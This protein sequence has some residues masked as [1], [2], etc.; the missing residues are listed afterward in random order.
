MEKQL[1]A[2]EQLA[3]IGSVL[4]VFGYVV[5]RSHF[6]HLGISSMASLGVEKYLAETLVL[7]FD[8]VLRLFTL[9]IIATIV[10]LP[11]YYGLVI[12]T[13]R[14]PRV[15]KLIKSVVARAG[16]W[17]VTTPA[18]LCCLAVLAGVTLFLISTLGEHVDVIVGDLD[19]GK[20]Q[21]RATWRFELLLV[22]CMLGFSLVPSIRRSLAGAPESSVLA[23]TRFFWKLN[24]IALVIALLVL[25]VLYGQAAYPRD[26]LWSRWISKVRRLM[27]SV[28]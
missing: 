4:A 6:N 26:F 22:I 11:I 14:L 18:A 2:L 21:D 24:G 12:V 3:K 27:T 19:L 5:L 23:R 8:I 7:G 20:L 25:P 13:L 16:S 17:L 9:G 1:K 15:R 28:G 10:I